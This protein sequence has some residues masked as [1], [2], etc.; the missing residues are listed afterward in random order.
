[1]RSQKSPGPLCVDDKSSSSKTAD[2]AGG[3][4]K[5]KQYNQTGK[6]YT[7]PNYPQPDKT[8]VYTKDI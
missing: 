1:M 4:V 6:K 5:N 7:G 3:G 2:S 8:I